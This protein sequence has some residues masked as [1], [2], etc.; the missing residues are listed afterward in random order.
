VELTSISNTELFQITIRDVNSERATVRVNLLLI[1][2]QRS[3]KAAHPDA[4]F[5]VWEQATANH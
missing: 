3:V 5:M 4:G 1:D 2:M